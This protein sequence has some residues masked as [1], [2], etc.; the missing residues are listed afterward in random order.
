MKLAITLLLL[1]NLILKKAFH[2]WNECM[3]AHNGSDAVAVPK[4]KAARLA[5]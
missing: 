5:F 4:E 3:R 1:H 2:T